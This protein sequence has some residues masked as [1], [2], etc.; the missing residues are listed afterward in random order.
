MMEADQSEPPRPRVVVT[1][2]AGGA[3]E[4]GEDGDDARLDAGEQTSRARLRPVSSIRSGAAR[5]KPSSVT[6]TRA[7]V[8]GPGGERPRC[9]RAAATIS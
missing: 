7:G 6:M 4:A 8:D 9:S 1:P 3:D 5:P 2:V